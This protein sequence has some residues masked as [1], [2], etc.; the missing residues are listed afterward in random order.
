MKNVFK[1]FLMVLGFIGVV[2][3]SSVYAQEAA[4]PAAAAPAAAAPVAAAP[5]APAPTEEDKFSFGKVVSMADGQITVKEYDF[6][7]DADVETV[8]SVTPE[9]ELGNINAVADLKTGD[10]IVI[11]YIEK[12]SKRV[13]TTLVKEEKGTEAMP[14]EGEAAAPAVPAAKNEAAAPVADAAAPAAVKAD[15]APAAPAAAD[16]APAQK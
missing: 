6:T 2:N 10:D 3:L 5:A 13:V 8:Y 1:L 12:D 7:K 11:D 16:A 14:G 9:T 4:A 15:A